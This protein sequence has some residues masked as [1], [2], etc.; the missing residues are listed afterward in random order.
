M[1]GVS[2]PTAG[3][4]LSME[5]TY[6]F[7]CASCRTLISE[8]VL[9]Y[10]LDV[11]AQATCGPQV[12]TELLPREVLR[13]MFVQTCSRS[14]TSHISHQVCPMSFSALLD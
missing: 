7:T 3:A 11:V 10:N 4:L 6:F 2:C 9:M 5:K 14:R 1:C 13:I 8:K 12:K